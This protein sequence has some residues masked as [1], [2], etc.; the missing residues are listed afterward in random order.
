MKNIQYIV[1]AEGKKIAVIM[2]IEEYERLLEDIHDLTIAK[3][4]I[5]EP[6]EDLDDVIKEFKKD[7][8]LPNSYR[9]LSQERNEKNR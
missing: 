9:A 4:R 6:T 5:N 8:L 7:G 1:D 3:E 2:P